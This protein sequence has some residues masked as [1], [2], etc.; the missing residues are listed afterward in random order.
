MKGWT[1]LCL[2]ENDTSWPSRPAPQ[3]TWDLK[4]QVPAGLV[5]AQGKHTFKPGVGAPGSTFQ[6]PR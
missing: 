2:L 5:D 6:L 1:L 4:P 3:G